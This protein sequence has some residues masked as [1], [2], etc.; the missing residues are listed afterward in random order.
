M[1]KWTVLVL[2]LALLLSLMLPVAHADVGN[3]AGDSDWGSDDWS[4]SD[5]DWDSGSDWDD[6]DDW[7]DGLGAFVGG[8]IGS[9]IGGGGGG[10][11]F[12]IV[13]I[14]I[15]V[16]ILIIRSRKGGG[17]NT[18]VHV[19]TRPTTTDLSALMERD[20]DFNTE[21]FL[22]KVRNLYVQM[23]NAWTDKDWE[24]MRPNLTDAFFNQLG[25]QLE[26]MKKAGQTNHVE[27]ISVLGASITGYEQR[28]N[29]DCLKVRLTTRIVDYT[30]DD[31]TGQVVSG[32]KNREKFLTYE[33]TMVRA[34]GAKTQTEQGARA[35]PNCGAPLDNNASYK[36]PYCGTVVK[37]TDYDWTLASIRGINQRTQ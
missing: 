34:Q 36:C 35:C 1:R 3:F 28:D 24:P 33:W 32:D 8:A 21:S 6:D 5:S 18:P 11:S 4:S 20:P 14:I 19:E 17:G 13:I 37:G 2:A 31:T 16:V 7:D 10:G 12:L 29:L 27:R 30:T 23:Q 22:E 9:S 15:V 25:R 26:E